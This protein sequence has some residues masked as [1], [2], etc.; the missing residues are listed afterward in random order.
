MSAPLTTGRLRERTSIAD[1]PNTKIA[2]SADIAAT[3]GSG[4]PKPGTSVSISITAPKAKAIMPPTPS[5]PKVGRN[6]SATMQPMPS[7]TSA[8]PA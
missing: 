5:A 4:T 1:M 8:S 2:D 7:A 3:I 6:S